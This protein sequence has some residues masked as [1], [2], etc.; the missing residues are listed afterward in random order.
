[1]QPRFLL[2]LSFSGCRGTIGPHGEAPRTQDQRQ[3]K[4][5]RSGLRLMLAGL[6]GRFGFSTTADKSRAS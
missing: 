1:M 5:L 4:W 6:Y 3:M 2:K